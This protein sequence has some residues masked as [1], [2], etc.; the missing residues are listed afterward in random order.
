MDGRTILFE[1]LMAGF[2]AVACIRAHAP[3]AADHRMTFG[4]FFR[5]S[6][7]LER[8]RR[9]RWQWFSMV[10]LMLVIRLQQPLPLVLEV[11]VGLQFLVFLALPVGTDTRSGVRR[12]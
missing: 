8:L 4:E 5:L 2:F 9:T 12:R 10:A 1:L 11:M 3:F 7:R 6:D